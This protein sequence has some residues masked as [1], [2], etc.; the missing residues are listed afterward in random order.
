MKKIIAVVLFFLFA[1]SIGGLRELKANSAYRSYEDLN[2]YGGKLISKWTSNE[3]N[4]YLKDVTKRKFWGWN[5]KFV[6]KELKC[7][8]T[9]ETLYSFYNDGFTPIDYNYSIK[10]TDK[11]KFELS[12]SGSLQIKTNEKAKIKETNFESGLDAQI[13]TSVTYST[14]HTKSEEMT[15]KVQVD[16]RTQV[17]VYIYGE[18]K[19]YNGVA[20]SYY[21]WITGHKGAFEIFLIT[22]QYMRLEKTRI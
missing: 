8:Y 21:F 18:G 13:K 16:P 17:T 9:T 20:A 1:L 4:N 12:V 3:Y 14:E 15:L 5:V 11:T 19:I 10:E 7:T 2:V 22:T 6:G